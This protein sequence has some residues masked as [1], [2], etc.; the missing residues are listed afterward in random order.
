[1]YAIYWYSTET[2]HRFQILY[3]YSIRFVT[4]QCTLYCTVQYQTLLTSSIN[5]SCSRLTS[6]PLL[7]Q[8]GESN[9]TARSHNIATWEYMLCGANTLCLLWWAGQLARNSRQY[10]GTDPGL[11]SIGNSPPPP[12]PTRTKSPPPQ[13]LTEWGGGGGVCCFLK[14]LLQE[15]A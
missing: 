4:V 15:K 10:F 3:I 1:M 7:Q 6:L 5:L 13:Y 9:R 12:H 14:M 8:G 11:D 2:E